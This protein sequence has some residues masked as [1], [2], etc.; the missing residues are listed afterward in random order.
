MSDPDYGDPNHC[1]LCFE[2][3]YGRKP[4]TIEDEPAATYD[5]EL[6]LKNTGPKAVVAWLGGN[7]P[8]PSKTQLVEFLHAFARRAYGTVDNPDGV[9]PVSAYFMRAALALAGLVD[10]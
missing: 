3:A 6:L 10:K 7:G 8:E 2:R 5:R 4:W 9:P 1:S